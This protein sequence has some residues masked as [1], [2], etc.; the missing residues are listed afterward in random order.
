MERLRERVLEAANRIATHGP[1]AVVALLIAESYYK[2][3]SF[4][5]EAVAFLATWYVVD[6]VLERPMA[7]IRARTTGW[8]RP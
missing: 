6:L 7:A 5:T 3:H 1:S 2:F 8:L 4:T